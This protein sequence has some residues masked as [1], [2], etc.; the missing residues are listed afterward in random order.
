MLYE[1]LVNYELKQSFVYYI[2]FDDEDLK[3]KV[4]HAYIYIMPKCRSTYVLGFLF[5]GDI[6]GES[7]LKIW[8][9][10]LGF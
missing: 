8:V 6:C 2:L 1:L 7:K 5:S 4:K 10:Q 9:C 3:L